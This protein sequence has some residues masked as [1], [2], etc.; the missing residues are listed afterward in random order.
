MRGCSID[1]IRRKKEETRDSS[2]KRK[3]INK[4]NKCKFDT[5]F[6]LSDGYVN[7]RHFCFAPLECVCDDLKWFNFWLSLE[8]FTM[9]STGKEYIGSIRFCQ[10]LT[11]KERA[12]ARDKI[13]KQF[14][15]KQNNG[16]KKLLQ[17]CRPKIF[18]S[19]KWES[20]S[21][22]KRNSFWCFIQKY[23]LIVND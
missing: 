15:S 10:S 5:E 19:Y 8:P 17:L 9:P 21:E 13:A 7:D 22:S 1:W 2:R 6:N 18:S 3:I 20:D 16:R 12:K 23:R 14:P 11:D 4:T